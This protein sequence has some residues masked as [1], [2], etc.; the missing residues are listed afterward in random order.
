V[1][2]QANTAMRSKINWTAV[3]MQ[4][5]TLL[6]LFDVIP[7]GADEAIIALVGLLGPALIQIFRTWF[8]IPKERG[9]P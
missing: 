5:L 3:L 7:H 1:K 9:D 8:T 4:V 6:V 2:K